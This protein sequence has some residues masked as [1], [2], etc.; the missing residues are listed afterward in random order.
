MLHKIM[1]AKFEIFKDKKGESRFRL[2]APNGEILLASEGYKVR[3]SALQGVESVRKNAS[4]DNCYVR[5]RG[6][7]GFTFCLKAGNNRIIGTSE[8]YTTE[9]AREKG[10]RAIKKHAP[11][12]GL[13]SP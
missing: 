11:K 5:K 2:K 4:L 7:A 1:A 6:K 3:R 12:A 10:I 8:S 9:A 13:K